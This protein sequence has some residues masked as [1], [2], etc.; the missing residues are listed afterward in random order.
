MA[1]RAPRMAPWLA[2][3]AGCLV[4][5]GPAAADPPGPAA[6]AIDRLLAEHW[7]TVGIKPAATADDA[8]QLRRVTLDLIG[9]VPTARERDAFAADTAPAKYPALVGRLV[10]GPE[11]AWY[12]AT[13]LDEVIQGRQ[14]GSEPFVN[15]LRAAL[16]D[17]KGWDAIFREVLIGP[18]DTDARKPAAG[19]LDRRVKDLDALTVD[20]TR[21]FFGVDISCARCHNHPLVK[22]WKRD[23]YYG[24]AA[25][26]VRTT[27][28]KGAV[29]EKADG[30]A[31]FAGKD[32]K[33]TVAPMMF[34][35]GRAVGGPANPKEK[36][37]RREALV[38]TALEERVFLS[39][40]VVNRVW[41][42]F[43]GRGLV[44]PVDQMHSGNPASVPALLDRLAADF[45]AGGYDVPGLVTAVALSRAY[46]LDSRW[47]GEPVPD[48]GHLAVARVR[49]LSPRQFARSLVLALDDRPF[50]PT[51]ERLAALDRQ[52]A[53]LLP[54]LDPRTAD[55]QSSAR[56][57]LFVSN[58]PAV[59]KLVSGSGLVTRLAK[60]DD[61]RALA[62]AAVR[63]VLARP[64]TAA[65]LG[66]LESW[67]KRHEGDRTA[68][69]EDLVWSLAASA[70][71]RFNH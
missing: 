70:E 61:D 42:H 57:A 10:R 31:K 50:D 51:P 33:E 16:R 13:V 8:T 37:S 9:R 28:G 46:R 59:R 43:F 21:A 48:P 67:L 25:F 40:A 34:L 71:F 63:A 29:T 24:M 68:A 19:F 2:P 22:D 35:T 53:E 30:E 54:A 52:A 27:G 14:A 17:N 4:L 26:L 23:H 39:R 65:E 18:W 66:E 38:R 62:T 1:P 60:V 12:F 36:F 64:A 41:E 45:A 55:F 56:E 11:F 44:D 7:R 3:L 5:V 20:T 69:S 47:A 58:A 49:P 32:G 6:A 15:Y